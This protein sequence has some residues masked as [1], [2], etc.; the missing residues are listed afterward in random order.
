MRPALKEKKERQGKKEGG[1]RTR[2]GNSHKIEHDRINKG[3]HLFWGLPFEVFQGGS[4]VDRVSPMSQNG[5]EVSLL[6]DTHEPPEI[7]MSSG[8]GR[9]ETKFK[10]KKTCNSP[11]E[12]PEMGFAWTE[13]KTKVFFH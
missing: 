5:A 3:G 7:I 9:R 2:K 6:E 10:K 8:K 13:R 1:I 11:K 12:R 4:G